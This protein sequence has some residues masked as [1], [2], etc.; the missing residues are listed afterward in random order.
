MLSMAT[1]LWCRQPGA[2][3]RVL[4]A[5][6]PGT[7]GAREAHAVTVAFIMLWAATGLAVWSLAI[8]M[9]NVWTHFIYPQE[10]RPHEKKAH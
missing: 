8:Y 7:L 3:D 2:A 5:L 9:S 1:L 4:T 6:L 10:V